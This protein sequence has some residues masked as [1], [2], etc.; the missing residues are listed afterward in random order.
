MGLRAGAGQVGYPE[1]RSGGS[2]ERLDALG[3][4]RLSGAVF[5]VWAGFQQARRSLYLVRNYLILTTCTYARRLFEVVSR[6]L[7]VQ[8]SPESQ[9]FM[10]NLARGAERPQE[11]R[12]P[13]DVG[14][15]T[16]P[17]GCA[18]QG[19]AAA[20]WALTPAGGNWSSASAGVGR[21]TLQNRGGRMWRTSRRGRPTAYGGREFRTASAIGH[22]RTFSS[23]VFCSGCSPFLP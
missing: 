1:G 16:R 17:D 4:R 9:A 8:N 12:S 15:G 5:V 10:E 7:V 13:G 14:L 3:R 21:S 22:R 18:L 20:R 23:P 6:C 19:P 11:P 2:A